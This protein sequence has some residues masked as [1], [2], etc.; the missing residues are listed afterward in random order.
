MA[1]SRNR[2]SRRQQLTEACLRIAAE[3]GLDEVSIREVASEAGVAIATV[4]YYFRT[5]D[6][7]LLFACEQTMDA[8]LSRIDSVDTRGTVGQVIRRA[9]LE[10]LPLDEGRAVELRVYFAFAAR[11]VVS[12]ELAQVHAETLA[13]FRANC[14]RAIRTAQE[15]GEASRDLD[16]EREAAV[17]VAAVDGLALHALTDLQ[18]LPQ[19][20]V[21][22]A[23]DAYL[24]RIFDIR[25]TV[26]GAAG[27][28][29]L[30]E[31]DPG[32]ER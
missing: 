26:S 1:S 5:K 8:A 11:S 25:G 17:L 14:A 27:H 15:I 6:E 24:R 20:E 22:A 13:Q 16:P 9:L 31:S 2:E 28:D 21:V 29:D 10:L 32:L 18:G 3:R 23:L 30:E 4:Q 19:E 12:D 7:L